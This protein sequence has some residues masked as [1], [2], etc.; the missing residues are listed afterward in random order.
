MN[1]GSHR[2]HMGSDLIEAA[3]PLSSKSTTVG[4]EPNGLLKV[5]SKDAL[6]VHLDASLEMQV[7]NSACFEL[8][9]FFQGVRLV[10][11]QI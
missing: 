5:T 10:R 4:K 8:S 3:T 11:E 6:I 2:T 7:V 9:E 1:P